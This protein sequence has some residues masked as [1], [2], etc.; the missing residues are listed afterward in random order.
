MSVS[1]PGLP[2]IPALELS[3][4]LEE[5]MLPAEELPYDDGEPLETV[6]HREA[7]NQLIEVIEMNWDGRKDFYV[8]GN[9]FVHFSKKQVFNKDF[10]GPDVFVVTDTDHD[11]DRLSWVMWEENWKL[12][13]LII[14]LVSSSTAKIDRVVK[15]KLYAETMKVDEYFCIDPDGRIEGWRLINS[16]YEPIPLVEGRIFS[17]TLGAF[18]GWWEC[19]YQN[20]IPHE[21]PRLFDLNGKLVPRFDERERELA[22]YQSARADEQEAKA[23][24][25]EAKAKQQEELAI[26]EKSRADAMEVELHKLREQLAQLQASPKPPE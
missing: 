19:S 11:R 1:E 14:E 15:K 16:M 12:P 4:T 6:W 13:N 17:E 23:K 18:I 24:Q 22:E 2:Y 20:R 25:Q 9:M 7:M 8:S 3:E 5:W 10:R 21:Y 26:T